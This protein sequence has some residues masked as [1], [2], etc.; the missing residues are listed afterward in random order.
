L[1]FISRAQYDV[2][3]WAR[4]REHTTEFKERYAKRAGIEGTVS[5]GT[6]SFGLRRS[7]YIGQVKTHLQHM[8]SAAAI[9]LARFAAW[10]KEI[11]LA[12]TRTSPLAALALA[13]S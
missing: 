9:N 10:I 11:P 13:Q 6:R 12:G 1:R 4:Q 7:R 5:Q 3:Q 2:L 8:M